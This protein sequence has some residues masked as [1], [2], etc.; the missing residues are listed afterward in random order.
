MRRV[1]RFDNWSVWKA[2][3]YN[4]LRVPKKFFAGFVRMNAWKKAEAQAF[5][6]TANPCQALPHHSKLR[7]T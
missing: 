2:N 4:G 5:G 1:L 3:K 7:K 6:L